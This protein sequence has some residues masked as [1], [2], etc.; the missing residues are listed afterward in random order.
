MENVSKQERQTGKEERSGWRMSASTYQSQMASLV[1]WVSAMYSASVL[2]RAT[3]F[4][5][6]EDQ[7]MVPP[8]SVKM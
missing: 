8:S 6:F 7:E 4:C 1:A 2:E 5:F 3:T